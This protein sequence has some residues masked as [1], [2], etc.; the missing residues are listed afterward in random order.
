MKAVVTN[1]KGE[2]FY[3]IDNIVNVQF[4]N[5]NLIITSLMEDETRTTQ[6]NSNKV[7]VNVTGGKID[8]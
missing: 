5:N 6:Y 4:V 8:G 3:E 1:I 7:I 2:Y